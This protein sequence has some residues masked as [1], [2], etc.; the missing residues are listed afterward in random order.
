MTML[1]FARVLGSIAA[2]LL[3]VAVA[4][5]FKLF[6]GPELQRLDGRE[7]P[8]ADNVET[9]SQLLVLAVI[10]SGVAATLAVAGWISS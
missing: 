9:A 1:E 4:V 7:V 8:K 6:R 2:I 10:L 3:I 5:W